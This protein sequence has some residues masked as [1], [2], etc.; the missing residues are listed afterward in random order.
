MGKVPLGTSFFTRCAPVAWGYLR[1][2]GKCLA[3]YLVAIGLTCAIL[4]CLLRLWEADF[5]VPFGDN[6]DSPCAQ[7][8]VKSIQEHGWFLH[9][10]NLGAPWGSDLYDFPMADDVHFFMIRLLALLIASPGRLYNVYFLLQFPLIAGTTCFV[11]RRLGIQGGLALV[12]SILYAF[13]PF[14]LLRG[15]NHIFLASYYLVP[16]QV[17]VVIRLGQ[18][19]DRQ[20]HPL[21]WRRFLG[22]AGLVLFCFL[23]AGAGIYYAFFGCIF[24]FLAGLHT[25]LQGR[26]WTSLRMAGLL[27]LITGMGVLVH[28]WPQISYIQKY[29]FNQDAVVRSPSEAEVFGLKLAHL[30]LPIDG[31]RGEYFACLKSRYLAGGVLNNENC[32]ASLGMLGVPPRFSSCLCTCSVGKAIAQHPNDARWILWL[33]STWALYWSG[34]RV[35]WGCC[36]VSW[37]PVGSAPITGFR[38]LWLFLLLLELHSRSIL[39]YAD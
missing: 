15:M 16:F 12:A 5:D 29:G 32:D 26:G 31:H 24:M 1:G 8:W 19:F 35:G 2:L 28:L 10:S 38:F 17:L 14:H 20:D 11:L 9:N 4:V 7:A 25:V 27:C 6:G 3:P 13:L 23:V 36:L 30:L 18:S 22:F 21:A 33:S 39:L 34:P 37:S